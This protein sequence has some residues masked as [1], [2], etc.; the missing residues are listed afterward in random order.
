MKIPT[1][2]GEI[3]KITSLRFQNDAKFVSRF[4]PDEVFNQKISGNH[5]QSFIH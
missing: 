1:I 2:C 5:C 4:E 3:R